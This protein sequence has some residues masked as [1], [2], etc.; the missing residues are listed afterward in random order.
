MAV[1]ASSTVC[2]ALE[3]VTHGHYIESIR[4]AA[5]PHPL[6][7]YGTFHAGLTGGIQMRKGVS[8]IAGLFVLCIMA[9]PAFAW[10]PSTEVV[11]LG[12]A[13]W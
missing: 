9:G 13:T 12:T 1:V 8:F 10:Y 2:P 3:Y 11:E 7:I 6:S 4:G 5:V